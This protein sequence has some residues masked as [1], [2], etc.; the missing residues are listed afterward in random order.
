MFLLSLI[1][2]VLMESL[3]RL[4]RSRDRNVTNTR[5]LEAE[6]PARSAAACSSEARGQVSA[7]VGPRTERVAACPEPFSEEKIPFCISHVKYLLLIL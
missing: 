6:V 7:E 1:P 4:I 5:R 2:L 3:D